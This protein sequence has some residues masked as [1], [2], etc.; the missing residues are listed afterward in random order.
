MI[1]LFLHH[2]Y[3][4]THDIVW[5]VCYWICN[6]HGV[7]HASLHQGINVKRQ[8]EHSI[9]INWIIHL[10][11]NGESLLGF[12]HQNV[13]NLRY[14]DIFIPL[15]STK[16]VCVVDRNPT[17]CCSAGCQNV[18][19]CST[20]GRSQECTICQDVGRCS[21]RGRSQKCTICQDVGRCS[22]RGRSQECTLCLPMQC[23]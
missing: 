17:T 10:W 9:N 15:N 1:N 8:E 14:M 4:I 16:F 2:I 12:T 3:C 21:T 20:R 7:I 19:R 11:H 22:T 23:E 5:R 6:I 13:I 18:G